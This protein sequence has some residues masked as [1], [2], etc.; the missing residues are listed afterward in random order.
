MKK[1][2]FF[3]VSIGVILA[4]LLFYNV[5]NI[6]KE[7][8]KN[9][10]E[11]GYILQSASG[12]TQKIDKYYFNANEEYKI[13]NNQK[14]IFKDTSGDE[15]YTTKDNFIHYN[16]G[17]ISSLQKGVLINLANI[18]Q[19]PITYYS[20]AANQIV[21]K[22]GEN[23]YINHLNNKLQFK[24]LI[25]KISDTKYLIAGNAMTV[26]F[27]DGTTKE[28]NGYIE[29]EYL[30]NQIIKLYNQE[31]IYQ[32]ISSKVNIKMPD[33]IEIN[34]QSKAVN[35]N[36][37][38]K[39]NLANMVI[40]SD[41]NVE[42]VEETKEDKYKNNEIDES[43]QNEIKTEDADEDED[44]EN[45]PNAQNGNVN[46]ENGQNIQ[47][48]ENS[49]TGANGE[50]NVQGGNAGEGTNGGSG[51][52]VEEEVEDLPELVA[53][54]F[55]VES[56][57]VDSISLNAQITI[58][59]DEARLVREPYIKI[60]DNATGKNVYAKEEALGT[61]NIDIAVSTLSP[62]TDYTLV[63]ESAY[64]VDGITYTKNFVY[65]IFRTKSV[66]IRYEKDVF[67]NNSLKF[68]VSVDPDSK[69]K[70]AEMSLISP[71]GTVEQTV[72]VGNGTQA[73][74]TA[75][76]ISLSSNTDYTIK[77]SNVLYNGQII[78]NGFSQE[79]V[80]RTLKNKPQIVG[81]E[82]EIDKRES[83][84]RLSIK[85][86]V[87][88]DNG[89]E[90]YRYEIYDTR[91]D[92][93]EAPVYTREIPSKEAITVKVDE[94]IL[95]RGV[96]YAFKVVAIFND[97][98][99]IVEYESEFSNVM[100][101]DGVEFPTVRFEK[102]TITFERIQGKLIIE[103]PN[104]TIKI[105]DSNKM[106]VTYT[107][108]TGYTRQ[109]SYQG[110]LTIPI[111]I[112]DLRSN[113]TY[114][115]RIFTTVDLKDDN[116]PID[117]CYIGGA[118]IQTL[119]PDALMGS[120][121]QDS[122]DTKNTFNIKFNLKKANEENA[123]SIDTVNP[124]D[125]TLQD[126]EANVLSNL[127]FRIYAGQPIQN[128]DGTVTMPG[129]AIRTVK[130]KDEYAQE[131][132]ESKIKEEYYDQV[133]AITPEFFG[134]EN[135]DFKDQKYTIQVLNAY[136]YTYAGGNKIPLV[137]GLGY[138]YYVVTTNGFIPDLPTDPDKAITVTP[139]R[140][141]DTDS[142]RT[143]LNAETIVGYKA[144]AKYDNNQNY[145]T[146]VIYNMYDATTNQIVGTQE[147]EIGEDGVV[148]PAEFEV[149]DGTKYGVQDVDEA[150]RGNKYY[151]TYKMILDLNHD[152]EGET[153]WPLPS[154]NVTLKSEEVEPNKQQPRIIMYPSISTDKAFKFKYKSLDI[155]NALE[156]DELTA[157]IN[158]TIKKDTKSIN[159]NTG[160]V[161]EEISFEN[162][163]AGNLEIRTKQRI[164]KTGEAVDIG[165]AYQYF[166]GK[167]N[168]QDL[169]YRL[170]V[171][172][173][174]VNITISGDIE[175]L[176]KIVAIKA[177]FTD[178]KTQTI[179]IEKDLKVLRNNMLTVSFNDIAE[180]L[181]EETRVDVEAYYDTGVTGYDV[182]SDYVAYQKAYRSGEDI[183]YYSINKEGNVAPTTTISENMFNRTNGTSTDKATTFNLV[184][185]INNK[186]ADF[187]LSYSEKGYTY[188]NDV[189]LQKEIGLAS[190]TPEGSNIIKFNLIIPGISLLK[191][192][193]T[194]EL[195]ITEELDRVKVNA[196]IITKD[197][198][199]IKDNNIIVELWKTDE[200]LNN[201]EK[202]KEVAI[203]LADFK[204]EI[205]I[206]GLEPKTYYYIKFRAE[207]R[208]ITKG[209]EEEFIEKY[210]YDVDYDTVGK[211]Y[212][213]ST[214]AN[215]N[216]ENIKVEYSPTS[217]A[218][219]DLKVS[220][221][222][223]KVL[224]FQKLRHI[225]YRQN[226]D[227]GAYEE[228]VAEFEDDL[229][230]AIMEEY[231]EANPG[232]IFTFGT[233]YKI[234]ITPIAVITNGE[235]QKEID[236]GT[237]E[238]E[239]YLAPLSSPLVGIDGYR[240]DTVNDDG[241]T[242]IGNR[243]RFKVTMY[244]NDRTVVGDKYRVKIYNQ[245]HEDITPEEYKG[246]YNTD[247][248]N[249]VFE[250]NNI[251]RDQKY[252]IEVN[253]DIDYPNDGKEPYIHDASNTRTVDPVNESGISVG[254]VT[255]TNNST[256]PNK[257]DLLFY[258]S[259]KID[260]IDQIRYS[261]YNTS[262]YNQSDV[263]DFVPR[264]IHSQV[265]NDTYYSFTLNKNLPT[266]GKYY[267]EMQFIR[268][269]EIVDTARIEHIF[270]N[271]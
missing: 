246:E 209:S 50:D 27:D 87:D 169:K 31:L 173:N 3:I 36:G 222:L 99:K 46:D 138:D 122:S 55:K 161:F 18:E 245:N 177:T 113:E 7:N 79:K 13:K 202:I 260:Q 23:Y 33:N 42:I 91:N 105:D 165:L 150:R 149:K 152:G 101:M 210:L 140:N 137:E 61:Y 243:I 214:L 143:E 84:F 145:A 104:N 72:E 196:S 108:S 182:E 129:T 207:I 199:E 114:K 231:V 181:N 53:P 228:K 70:G 171:E 123:G 8:M 262:G 126:L 157:Y 132:Y 178:T 45:N 194:S 24:N 29:L 218:D 21:K 198:I 203:P 208:N 238:A 51:G 244:D 90:G 17:A 144:Q 257:I 82:Y 204:N 47:N 230:K 261:I 232:S 57:D 167:R 60:L 11:P 102:E 259:Y 215:V 159:P 93:D 193:S 170:E 192:G 48:G 270:V 247:D 139:I 248:A 154:D 264:E 233:R 185:P 130:I 151:F 172:E 38:T 12:Q 224:G 217:Y 116:D 183:N 134:A 89:I 189:V 62:E 81:P 107:D 155:D 269:G 133:K 229:P 153:E 156:K 52:I 76:F 49:Q 58:Q 15:V 135:K 34:L 92:L 180:L 255:S 67:T 56:F 201:S 213:F 227:T 59:D 263:E 19:D 37:E 225:I 86:V 266:E 187:I 41:D 190:L 234:F 112:N 258:N 16:N 239:F 103:D 125:P 265:D 85:N 128:G 219:K 256:E 80:F 44:S 146:K 69:V 25:W 176:S 121:I 131:P 195:D 26:T 163:V 78:S 14:V 254:N 211:L 166:E 168:I 64:D 191:E 174:S 221:T 9:F 186:K 75:E 71:N 179:K 83:T 226:P 164:S 73:G 175:K 148:P 267:V 120:F 110:G 2:V 68:K 65:K 147:I 28:I 30:D 118:I 66:G 236:L 253:M 220:Y 106:L 251:A 40:D 32:T 212:Y 117:E 95:S 188:Q 271:G 94:K 216:V 268:N 237:K 206:D 77:L 100:K 141:R 242:D 235:E 162:L 252:T 115:F 96:P 35:K 39:M 249:N 6:Q 250:L 98:E 119:T 142:P 223:D 20:I 54:V 97:N 5:Y 1:Y 111:D 241:T 109:F 10:E 158:T 124:D 63:I 127:E 43:M 184:N 74:E 160:D 136:D 22:Q 88:Q 205:T 200:N 197:G 240:L 4:G